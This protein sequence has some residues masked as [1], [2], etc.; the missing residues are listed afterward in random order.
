MVTI[1]Y[2]HKIFLFFADTFVFNG[3]T[4]FF[5]YHVH[6]F[7][8]QGHML[9]KNLTGKFCFFTDT[10]SDFLT[11]AGALFFTGTISA[12]CPCRILVFTRKKKSTA[13]VLQ[14]NAYIPVFYCGWTQSIVVPIIISITKK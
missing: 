7:E 11:L 1:F 14:D 3:D 9:N 5:F 13:S 10:F 6:L 8:F 4:L 12:F 2:N